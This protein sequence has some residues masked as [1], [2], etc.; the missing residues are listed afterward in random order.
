M[1]SGEMQMVQ[2]SSHFLNELPIWKLKIVAAEYGIDVSSCKYKRDFVEK[3]KAKRLTDDQVRTAL[4]RAKNVPTE[5]AAPD[6]DAAEVRAIGADIKEISNKPV[7]PMELP[8]EDE[9]A[10]ERNIDEAL[11]MK[12]S[13][14]EIDSTA[15][16]ALNKLILG[17]FG[18]AIRINRE[19]RMMSLG[20]FSAFQ[21]Y[22]TAL[23]I[24]AAD[25]LLSK[26]PDDKGRLDPALRTAVAAAKRSFIA[27]SPRQREEALENLETLAAKTYQAFIS[28]SGQE[29]EELRVLLADYESFGTRTEEARKFLAIAESAKQSSN[30]GEY[31]KYIRDARK[32]A[33]EAKNVRAREIEN[34]IPLVNAAAL[35]AKE[36]GID[37]G[38]AESDIGEAKKALENGAFKRAIDLLAAIERTVDAAHIEQIKRQ[39]DLEAR[40]LEKATI[41][42]SSHEPVVMEAASYGMDVQQQIGHIANAKYALERRDAVNAVKHARVL[43]DGSAKMEKSLDKK[44][45]DAGVLKHVPD[46]KCGRCGHKTLYSFP[47][48]SQKCVEC[49]HSFSFVPSADAVVQTQPQQTPAVDQESSPE[50]V[51][52]ATQEPIQKEPEKRKRFLKW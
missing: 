24:R 28:S 8:Q 26:V 36:I 13:F 20:N 45:I 6:M 33:E 52:I 41:T 27:G 7:E 9:K 47:N 4:S 5:V 19:A 2:D 48:A 30:L 32:R 11:T 35:E 49:G 21:V 10:V 39:R 15:E 31:A 16:G 51:N 44:R 18:E 42:V 23:S 34:A 12:P 50:V 40:Q 25:E 3:V 29:E 22:S 46:A 38:S 14:F 1:F 43:K 17:D 37:T